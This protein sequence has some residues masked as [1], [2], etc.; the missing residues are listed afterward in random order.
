MRLPTIHINGTSAKD[1]TEGY[2]TAYRAVGDAID[3]VAKA[4]PNGR[5]YY[6]QG[7]EAIQE[8]CNEHRAR[9]VKLSEVQNELLELCV[10]CR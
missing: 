6:P 4:G 9:L 8:A 5:D 1:L 3:A 7:G 10:A 2:L